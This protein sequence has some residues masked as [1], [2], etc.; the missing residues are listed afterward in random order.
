MIR[1]KLVGLFL[2]PWGKP[3]LRPNIRQNVSTM[4]AL[5]AAR[6]LEVVDALFKEGYYWES[7]PIVRSSYED[8]LQLAFLLRKPDDLRCIEF[9]E[10]VHRQDAG[11]YEAFSALCG[12]EATKL[13]FGD[14]PPKVKPFIGHKRRQPDR[15]QVMAD[16]VNLRVVHD[17]VYPYLSGRSHP[18]SRGDD[19]FDHSQP[20][21]V[22]LLPERNKTE[23]ILLAIWASWFTARVAVLA[24]REF[25]IDHERFCDEN[26][27]SIA[28]SKIGLE[29]CVLVRERIDREQDKS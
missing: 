25:G 24:S 2:Q 27:L 21:S 19:L 6:R 18:T 4:F 15:F 17:F 16:D 8:W 23:E 1:P 13:V 3:V 29:T 14:P 9:G 10:D 7:H 26:L 11:L 20:V 28:S 5:R 12:Q 22:A